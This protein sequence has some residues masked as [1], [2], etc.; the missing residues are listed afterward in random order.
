MPKLDKITRRLIIG[1]IEDKPEISK[2]ALKEII[3][4]HYHADV[5]ALIEQ[6]LGRVATQMQNYV[7][8]GSGTRVMFSIATEANEHEFVNVDLSQNLQK[9]KAVYDKLKKEQRARDRSISK[10][11]ESAKKLARAQQIELKFEEI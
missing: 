11:K 7:R 2:E 10:V 8:D 5:D 1:L 4:P 3:R 9:I 6:D